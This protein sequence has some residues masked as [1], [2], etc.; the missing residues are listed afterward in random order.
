MANNLMNID[1]HVHSIHSNQPSEFM[2]QKVQS[3]ECYT[4]PRDV[5]DRCLDR[6]MSLV[7][8]TDHDTIKG[9]LEIAHLP[10]TFVSEEITASFPED[11][12]NVHVVALDID[13]AQ[14][15]DIQRSREN[16]Y[17]L[18]GYLRA[19]QVPHFVA[20]PLSKVKGRLTASHIEKLVLLFKHLEGM[21]GTRDRI[22]GMALKRIV[23]GL[24]RQ[25]LYKWA[26]KHNIR[27]V[28]WSPVRYLTAGSDDHG[29]LNIARAYTELRVSEHTTAGFREAFVQGEMEMRGKFGNPDVLSH[30]IYAVTYQYFKHTNASAFFSNL[31]DDDTSDD[32]VDADD[33]SLRSSRTREINEVI[34]D[35]IA[36]FPDFSPMSVFDNSH[37][38]E[39]Q[40]KL[41]K[42]G[43]QII[44]GLFQRFVGGLI[45]A[46]QDIDFE[47]AFDQV[48]GILSASSI[49]LP[50]LFGYRYLVRDREDSEQLAAGVGFGY[51]PKRQCRVA[52]FT[53]TGFDINGVNL[54]LRRMIRNMRSK[55]HDIILATCATPPENHTEDDL[56]KDGGLYN[57]ERIG[58]FCIPVYQEMSMGIPSL[59]DVMNYLAREHVSIVQLSTPGP[60]GL[61]AFFAARLMGIPVVTNYHTEI[62]AYTAKI[63][64][65]PAITAIATHWTGWFYRQAERVIAP[66][67]AAKESLL[68]LGVEESKISVLPRGVDTGLFS[69]HKREPGSWGRFGLNGA[70][71]LLYVGRVS[72]EK[73]LDTLIDAFELLRLEKR[74]I[75]L[76]IVGEGPYLDALRERVTDPRLIFLGYRHGE[77]LARIFASSDVFVFPSATDTFGNVVL[78]AQASGLPAVVVDQGG[79]AEQVT[80]GKHGF[81][82]PAG[83]A[84]EMARVIERLLDDS[85]LRY[86]M[87]R[88]AQNRALSLSLGSAAHAQ[89]RFYLDLWGRESKTVWLRRS[90][91]FPSIAV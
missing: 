55:G 61:I 10:D 71:K 28:D 87:G 48:P 56:E 9:A 31:D 80:D 73:G 75:D 46:V 2:L 38:D 14:H 13:E 88:A 30:N 42:L 91:G 41:G 3:G 85:A 83:D 68:E 33:G 81:V 8:I 15:A 50:Y 36:S 37:T 49:I 76:A 32:N 64:G 1:L 90:S 59:V 5:Y 24:T 67:H 84:K 72:R 40:E 65:D 22:G 51:S 17:D 58:E 52:V 89:W 60:L 25:H 77:D 62:P 63:T 79:P 74:Q 18:V 86:R 23:D 53:D 47:R 6:G 44:N 69:A 34:K 54:G 39:A 11:R 29:R 78:E 12:V 7:T 35:A 19:E 57:F 45:D 82:V 43:R 21:N 16:I 66:S 70:P 27:P 20:H 4:E 26:E